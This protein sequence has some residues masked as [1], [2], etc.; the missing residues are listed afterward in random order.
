MTVN[1]T[2]GGDQITIVSIRH[3]GDDQR[4]Q[5]TTTV[6]DRSRRQRLDRR[7]RTGRRRHHRRLRLGAS[8]SRSTA[9]SASTSSSAASKNDLVNGGDGNDVALLGAGDDTFVWNPGDDND[10]VEGQAGIDTMLFNG[11]NVAEN[12]DISANGGRVL[13]SRDIANVTMDLNDVERI[14]FNALG[15]ADNIRDPR[16]ER[17]RRAEVAINLAGRRRLPATVSSTPS[18]STPPT[19]TT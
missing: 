3:D 10:T 13:F 15:G 17:H 6:I 18:S 8:R 11:A 7:E 9:A 5:A 14:T 16:S 2:N 1:G 19:A 12:I 4:P